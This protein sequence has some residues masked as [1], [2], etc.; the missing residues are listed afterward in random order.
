HKWERHYP[1]L[2]RIG[3]GGRM[4]WYFT[5]LE[6]DW[7]IQSMIYT[8][9]WIERLNRDYKR[10]TGMR[11]ALPDVRSAILLLGYVA[12]TRTAYQRK[13]PKLNYENHLFRWEESDD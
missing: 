6:Y 2:S 11:G 10:I 12:M 9:H 7:R 3:K 13:I 4:E 5:Y 8:T 1:V